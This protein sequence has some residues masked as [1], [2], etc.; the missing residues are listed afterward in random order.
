MSRLVEVGRV[1]EFARGEMRTVKVDNAE[2]GIV[3]WK[4]EI[5][6]IRN[7]CPHQ[8]GPVCGVLLDDYQPAK[9]GSV[10]VGPNPPRVACAWHH[11]EFD[12]LTGRSVFNPRLKVKTYKVVVEDGRLMVEV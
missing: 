11:W 10:T 6:A 2:I 9:V 8:G 7:V 3:R 5:Y 12:A 4:S 1:E